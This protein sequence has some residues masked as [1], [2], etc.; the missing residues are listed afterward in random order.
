MAQSL[1][2]QH[3]KAEI[4]IVEGCCPATTNPEGVRA[5]LCS[6]ECC[7]GEP[8][9][10]E[11]PVCAVCLDKLPRDIRFGLCSLDPGEGL[12]EVFE[13]A[14]AHLERFGGEKACEV[15]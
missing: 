8:K 13:L 2:E 4:S 6:T 15:F 10:P 7:C 14:V 1:R 11:T 9:H 3:P 12:E 5:A